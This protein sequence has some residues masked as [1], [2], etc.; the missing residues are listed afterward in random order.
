MVPICHVEKLGFAFA[1]VQIHHIRWI[2]LST[3]HTVSGFRRNYEFSAAGIV[4]LSPS[5]E[6]VTILP[7]ALLFVC[8]MTNLAISLPAPFCSWSERI[9][10][11]VYSTPST[12]AKSELI[13]V[14]AP[15]GVAKLAA[16]IELATPALQER[17]S[18]W[19]SYASEP[20]RA[21]RVSI[22]GWYKCCKS[23]FRYNRTPFAGLSAVG[24]PS[25]KDTPPPRNVR[26]FP[27]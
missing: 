26:L 1:V 6:F 8:L 18:A 16:R 24:C 5:D 20:R 17:R 19:L 21:E 27:G 12:P 9:K 14:T 23:C 11:F 22:G 10:G 4:R 7:I 2:V 25:G 3:V 13:H 15:V